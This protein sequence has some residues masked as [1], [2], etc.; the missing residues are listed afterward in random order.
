MLVCAAGFLTELVQIFNGEFVMRRVGGMIK[1]L[2]ETAHMGFLKRCL[3]SVSTFIATYVPRGG[4]ADYIH[5][6]HL[7]ASDEETVDPPSMQCV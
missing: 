7:P 5:T 1:R 2:R 6:Y 3:K 4:I